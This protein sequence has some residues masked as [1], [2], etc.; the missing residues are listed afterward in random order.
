MYK[1]GLDTESWRSFTQVCINTRIFNFQLCV[2]VYLII[3]F[4]LYEINKRAHALIL[5]I[6]IYIYT[7]Y[8]YIDMNATYI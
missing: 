6:Y 2:A 8:T 5:Y 3:L 7:V 4:W 1:Y